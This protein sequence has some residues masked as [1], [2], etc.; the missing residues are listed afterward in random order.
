MLPA[1]IK[2][3]KDTIPILEKGGEGLVKHFYGLL[4]KHDNVRPLFNQTHQRSGAQP[5]ALAN[6]ILCYARNIDTLE[7]LG[8]LAAQIVNKHVAFQIM[9][10]H[11]PIVGTCLLRSIREVLGEATAT[12][13]VLQAWGAAYLQLADILIAA[14]AD[15]YAAI[16][17]APGGWS[18][19][20]RFRVAS[21]T[22]ANAAGDV[23]TFELAPV[24]GGPVLRAKPGQYLTIVADSVPGQPDSVRRNYSLSRSADGSSYCIT[25]KRLNGGALSGWLHDSVAVGDELDIFPPAGEFVLET[26]AAASSGCPFTGAGATSGSPRGLLL[27]SAGV[28]ITPTMAMLEAAT[29][30]SAPARQTC[31][32]HYTQD[33]R[34]HAF[35][36]RVAAIA[37]EAA[38]ASRNGSNVSLF[39]A[40]TAPDATSTAGATATGRINAEHIAAAIAA[41]GGADNVDVYVLGPTGFMKTA[42]ELLFAAGVPQANVKHE[43][44]GPSEAI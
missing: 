34:T 19:R 27:V 42:R 1:Q 38:G 37:N 2:I 18:G 39:T 7:N 8:P 10:D 33:A 13:E 12:D 26:P 15:A 6:S 14:E 11:Y 44:F 24:D 36:D 25:V 5:R 23:V 43:F 40:Y 41:A 31:F 20:R 17:A 28:G 16:A 35:A 29:A 3:I 22:A 21:K 30:P 9:P 32:M 4:M